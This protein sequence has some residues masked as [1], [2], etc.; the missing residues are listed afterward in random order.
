MDLGLT[1]VPTGRPVCVTWWTSGLEA[2]VDELREAGLPLS[3]DGV[4]AVVDLGPDRLLVR[5]RAGPD[6]LA[7]EAGSADDAMAEFTSARLV[8]I[9]VATV[10]HE[11]LAGE[12]GLGGLDGPFDEPA[13][14]ARGWRAVAG[15]RLLL[16]E[17]STEGRLAASLA[18]LGEGPRVLYLT[19]GAGAGPREAGDGR[20]ST[21]LGVLG[22]LLATATRWGPFAILVDHQ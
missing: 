13:L 6:G 14:G 20:A 10:D 16:L 7:V 17:P 3:S 9:G 4:G 18:R 15:S 8:G 5:A 19:L 2:L 1:T 11:R 22:V 12:L 21:G